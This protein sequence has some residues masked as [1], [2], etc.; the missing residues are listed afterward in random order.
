MMKPPFLMLSKS[1]Q[2][3]IADFLARNP[4]IAFIISPDAMVTGVGKT[5]EPAFYVGFSIMLPSGTVLQASATAKDPDSALRVAY[6]TLGMNF[7]I[8]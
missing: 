3:F 1:L 6:A 4:D 2:T 8:W 5:E 7:K